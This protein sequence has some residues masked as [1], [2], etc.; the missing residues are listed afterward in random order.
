VR[1]TVRLSDE[2]TLCALFPGSRTESPI[3]ASAVALLD[4][5]GHPVVAAVSAKTTATR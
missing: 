1:V 2:R 3:E 5:A 4:T